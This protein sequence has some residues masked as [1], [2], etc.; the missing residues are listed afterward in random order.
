ME[1]EGTGIRVTELAPGY[2]DT[3]MNRDI[4][5][6]PFVVSAERAAREMADLIERG[7]AQAAVPRWPWT[8]LG[9]LMQVLPAA[10]LRR[11]T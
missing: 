11:M 1:L 5:S 8:L 6:R 2:I 10:L 4:P 9:R 3:P 7:V